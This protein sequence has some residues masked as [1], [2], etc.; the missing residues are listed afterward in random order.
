MDK[1]KRK[2]IKLEENGGSTPLAQLDVA[3]EQGDK[4]DEIAKNTIPKDVQK[5]TIEPGDQDDLA[6][7]FFSMLK[8][9]KGDKGDQ[10]EKGDMGDKGNIG[11][12]G[13]EGKEGKKGEKGDTGENGLDGL[14]GRDGIDGKDGAQGKEGSPD[15]TEQ[16]FNKINEEKVFK[17]KASQI[18]ELPQ[19]TREVVREIGAHGGAY[20]T[21]IKDSTGKPISKDASGA[22]I[23]PA[24]GSSLIVTEIDGS[25]SGT[26]TILKFSNGSVTDNGDGS[27]TITTGSGGGGDVSSN[28]IT[29]VDNEIVLFSGT[30]G[31]TI[32]RGSGTGIATLTSGVLS[33]TGT[34]GSGNVVLATSATL[35]TPIL[36]TPQSVILTNGTGLPISGL[37]GLGTGVGTA[38]AVNVGSAGAFVTFNGALGTP[39]SGTLINA[40][41]L[42]I[43]GITGLGTGIAT[44]LATPS[45]ANLASAIP[46][47]TGSGSLVFAT[48]PTVS[49]ASASTAVTQ[50][51]GDGSTKVATTAYVD[52]AINGT[53]AKDA[54][55]YA[56]TAALPS[57]IY[58]NGSSGVGATLTGVALA[59][60]S[61]DSSSPSV[62][63]R[64]LIKNQ[65][66]NFQNGIYT[67]TATGS[68][69]A[70]FVLT[71][72]SD[73]DQSADIDIGDSVFI[74]AGTVNANTTWVQNGTQNPVM[75]TDPIT[76]SQIAGPG[77]I[78]SGNGITVTGL[79]VAIDTSVTVDKTTAQTLTNKT[80]TSPILTTPNLGTPSAVTLTNGTGLPI[81]GL[82]ASTTQA[83]GVGSIELGAATDTTISRV[84]AG[85]IAVEGVT[86]AST[87]SPTFTG[88]VTMNADV[89]MSENK[90]ILMDA[91][92]SADGK[93]SLI[94]GEAGTLGETVAFGE[95]IYLKASDSQW[96]KTD[97]DA[98]ATSGAVK[99]AV[100]CFGGNDNDP[101]VVMYI[102]KIRADSLFPTFTISAPIFLSG[103]AGAVTNTAPTATDTV[104]RI[105][106][107][108]NTGDEMFVN[109][110]NDYIT[111]V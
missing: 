88:T 47:E 87:V 101:T 31:K 71:R 22:F 21:P 44:W 32:K 23:L 19:F 13:P 83:I 25:P 57:I 3:L 81:A 63:D 100:C 74:T 110:S 38:L 14:D 53:D 5:V 86:L 9:K 98:T 37:T 79:S 89:Q 56:S 30:D 18:S 76:F 12:Q 73:F 108:G 69:I 97:A 7:Q 66:S 107:Y 50:T 26:P 72:T 35:V 102:G 28:T 8:G 84:S 59:A 43:A 11:E 48:G 58:A 70:V 65:A 39:S 41:G 10:G 109:I 78:T 93:Y 51:P 52:A 77:A 92:L 106:G 91:A 4:L 75:G 27:F 80:L 82:V 2:G 99:V 45:S 55:K 17:I 111:H 95:F 67:V 64:V 46:D 20:E 94:V 40:T 85:V 34:T 1:I 62:G 103:T 96:Y 61:L 105:V 42:P 29:S 6:V 15:T 90:S 24:S 54:C 60:I 16:L 36:G 49:L 68:G 33:A 104:S